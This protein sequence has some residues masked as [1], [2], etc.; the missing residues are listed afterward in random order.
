MLTCPNPPCRKPI[1]AGARECPRCRT[2]LSLL[3]TYVN[4]LRGGLERAKELTRAGEL[5]P[6]VWTYLEVLEVDPENAT[7]RRQVGQVAAAVRQFDRAAP[8]RRWLKRMR[9]QARFRDWL[10]ADG[11]GRG[12]L[13]TL[14]WLL[15]VLAAFVLGFVLGGQVLRQPP[16]ADPEGTAAVV[17]IGKIPGKSR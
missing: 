2:D 8:G 4:D 6:A 7:A 15:M 9:R 12:W 3:V 17:P 13:G 11:D 10:S 14:L 1:P 16:P 5:G